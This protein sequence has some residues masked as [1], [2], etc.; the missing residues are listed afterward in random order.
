MSKNEKKSIFYPPHVK[1]VKHINVGPVF[2]L[3]VVFKASDKL[4]KRTSRVWRTFLVCF[5]KFPILSFYP[6]ARY[7]NFECSLERHLRTC[8]TCHF[9]L[10]YLPPFFKNIH[11]PAILVT[12]WNWQSFFASVVLL[13]LCSSLFESVLKA[14]APLIHRCLFGEKPYSNEYFQRK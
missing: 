8:Q 10:S 7:P 1:L 6:M 5:N 13:R 4:I 12:G 3:E 2:W 14:D 9:V 11:S